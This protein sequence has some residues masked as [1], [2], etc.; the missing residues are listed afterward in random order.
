MSS[1][2]QHDKL[3]RVYCK[4]DENPQSSVDND[5]NT[6]HPATC[7]RDSLSMF[8]M[9]LH[10]LPIRHS[11]M[12][13]LCARDSQVVAQIECSEEHRKQNLRPLFQHQIATRDMINTALPLSGIVIKTSLRPYLSVQRCSNEKSLPRW[14]AQDMHQIMLKEIKDF[15]QGLKSTQSRSCLM[16]RN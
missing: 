6:G 1:E 2:R 8:Y 10:I 7:P 9:L 11:S 14:Q 12:G 13:L 3:K 15:R 4:R 16:F 5:G